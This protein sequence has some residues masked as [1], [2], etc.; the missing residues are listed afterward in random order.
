MKKPKPENKKRQQK[1][2]KERVERGSEKKETCTPS[3]IRGG[4]GVLDQPDY[5]TTS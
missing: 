5:R 4:Q 1:G 2:M 3:L